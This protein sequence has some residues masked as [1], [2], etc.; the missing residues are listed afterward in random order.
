[1]WECDNVIME[2]AVQSMEIVGLMEFFNGRGSLQSAGIL[3]LN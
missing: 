1:M 3:L 2:E